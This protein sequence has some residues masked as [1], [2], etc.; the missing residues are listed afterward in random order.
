MSIGT[1]LNPIY[2]DSYRVWK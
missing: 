1:D 2:Q